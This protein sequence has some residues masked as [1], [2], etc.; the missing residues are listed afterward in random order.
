MPKQP[1]ATEKD[2]LDRIQVIYL[3]LS[4]ENLAADGERSRSEIKRRYQ[5]LQRELRTCFKWL[6]REVSEEEAFRR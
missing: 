2:V 6:G 5:A 4:P 3:E 1:H